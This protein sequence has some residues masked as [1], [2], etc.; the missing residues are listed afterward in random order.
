MCST[1]RNFNTKDD[2]AKHADLMN[3][4]SDLTVEIFG[5]KG[6]HARGTLG[7]SSTSG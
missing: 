2:Y 5:D 3:I 4:A 7:A 1:D 6:K